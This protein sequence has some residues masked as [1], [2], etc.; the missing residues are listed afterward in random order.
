M[1]NVIDTFVAELGAGLMRASGELCGAGD[2]LFAAQ[3]DEE[4]VSLDAC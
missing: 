2:H 4:V 1:L 3:G